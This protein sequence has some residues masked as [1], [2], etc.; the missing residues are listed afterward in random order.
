MNPLK[1][2]DLT[3]MKCNTHLSKSAAKPQHYD[4]NTTSLLLMF[5]FREIMMIECPLCGTKK[6][7]FEK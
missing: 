5:R 1:E 7:L 2:P 4:V 3:C 6:Y